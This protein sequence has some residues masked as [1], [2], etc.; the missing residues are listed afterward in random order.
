MNKYAIGKYS[1]KMHILHIFKVN[2][3]YFLH[4]ILNFDLYIFMNHEINCFLDFRPCL[5][6]VMLFIYY[7]IYS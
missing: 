4:Y 7:S 3:F 1:F 6:I 5:S 2:L